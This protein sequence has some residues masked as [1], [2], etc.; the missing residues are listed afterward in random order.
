[1]ATKKAT[2]T[3]P[4]AAKK[5]TI[6]TIKTTA[7]QV[8]KEVTFTANEVA[9]DVME[10]GKAV[11]AVAEKAAKDL[12]KKVDF[13]G[14][15]KKIK[16]TANSVNKQVVEAATEV[17]DTIMKNGKQITESTV[18][19]AK[20]AITQINVEKGIEK[21]T[22]TAKSV[23][24]YAL[25]TADETIDGALKNGEKWSKVAEKA[26]N[27]SLKLAEKNQ[28]M[29]FTT[30]ETVKAQMMSNAIRFSR[31]FSKN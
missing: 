8:N 2:K 20:E 29:V 3:A 10:N 16:F 26:V 18:K 17:A 9:K 24:E 23:N 14:S 27:G 28:E 25:K 15:T 31:L 30:L 7:T 5:N 11:K 4:K 12:T 1:M 13:E 6:E 21:V 22:A 19:V